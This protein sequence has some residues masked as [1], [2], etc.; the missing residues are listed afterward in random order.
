MPRIGHDFPCHLVGATTFPN[1]IGKNLPGL[2]IAVDLVSFVSHLSHPLSREMLV[3]DMPKRSRK[4]SD[5]NAL[6]A[7]IVRE[8]TGTPALSRAKNPAAVSLG[9]LGG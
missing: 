5:P 1:L 7:S 4:P 8:T 6:A 3:F 9:R 2:R